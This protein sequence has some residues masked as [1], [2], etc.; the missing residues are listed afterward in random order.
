MPAA[1]AVPAIIGAASIGTSVYAGAKASGAASRAAYEQSQS[2]DYAAD[3]GYQSGQQALAEQQRQF[4]VGQQLAAPG[5]AAGTFALNQLMTGLGAQPQ[6]GQAQSYGGGYNQASAAEYNN[7][8]GALQDAQTE[9]DNLWNEQSSLNAEGT[10]HFG[11]T[12]GLDG[13]QKA[14]RIR[15]L[16]EQMPGLENAL[17]ALPDP[18][19]AISQALGGFG[20]GGYTQQNTHQGGGGGTG[21]GNM[22]GQPVSSELLNESGGGPVA[23]GEFTKPF[24]YDKYTDPSTQFRFAEGQKALERGAAARGG[25]LGGAALKAVTRYGQDYMSNEYSKAYGRFQGERSD[26]WNRY[27]GLAGLGQ[28]ASQGAAAAG[29]QYGTNAA[30]TMMGTAGVMGD[31][32][33]QAANAR[34]S[35]YVGGSNAWTNALNQGVQGAGNMYAMSQLFNQPGT[36]QATSIMPPPNDMT[37]IYANLPQW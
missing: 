21:P 10:S 13:V 27:A 1:V 32:A 8:Q 35:G 29:A 24:E 30:N 15:E 4:N 16:T 11:N 19:S 22:V 18:N 23:L 5:V 25:A 37:N 36:Q 12:S 28:T 17:A 20:G 26:L 3:L 9:L 31:Y 7:A 2:A 14:A 33:T 34:A 6:Q